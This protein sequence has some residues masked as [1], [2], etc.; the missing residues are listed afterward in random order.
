MLSLNKK[1]K[2][3]AKRALKPHSPL[4]QRRKIG[5]DVVENELE[6]W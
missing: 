5:F 4:L 3:K 2:E 6:A 1:E